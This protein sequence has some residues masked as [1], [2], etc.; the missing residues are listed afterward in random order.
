M[1]EF[2]NPEVKSARLNIRLEQPDIRMLPQH[3]AGA[4]FQPPYNDKRIKI[5]FAVLEMGKAQSNIVS[6][7]PK[8]LLKIIK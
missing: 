6:F 3:P 8:K 4:A 5:G 2:K 1:F 7:E